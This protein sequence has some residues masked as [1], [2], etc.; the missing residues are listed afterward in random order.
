MF[1]IDFR[2]STTGEYWVRRSDHICTDAHVHFNTNNKHF[3]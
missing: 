1:L 3:N 2:L